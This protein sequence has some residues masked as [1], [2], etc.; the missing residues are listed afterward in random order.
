M[1]SPLLVLVQGSTPASIIGPMQPRHL[2]ILGV[3][4]LG[5]SIGLAVRSRLKGCKVAGYGHRAAALD[6]ALQMGAIDERYEDPAQAVRGADF[7]IL[8]TPVGRLASL[9]AE[10]A[11]VLSPGTIVTD[12]GSTKRAVVEAAE[13]SLPPGVHFVGSHPMAGSEKR[14]V[15]FA[16]ADLFDRAVCIT[17]PTPHTDPQ[18]LTNVESF[19]QT[20]GMRTTRLDPVEHD[21]LLADVS[22]LPHA[23][24][25]ALVA[26][27]DDAALGLCGKGFL[28][29]TRIAG[30]DPGLWR[31]ILLENRQNVRASLKRLE[32]HL[33]ELDGLLE[34]GT[35]DQLEAWLRG[36]AERREGLLLRRADS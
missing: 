16:R 10:I 4:L 9:L 14:G 20:L 23:V 34:H 35:P 15:E 25:G 31:D 1:F 12:V 13:Q 11:P 7:V 17:T 24:A 36:A 5:G 19:W 30:G 21:R 6:V 33:N 26:M 3:G 18:A 22:H 28:D 2:A 29:M 8:C 32:G 27:Q